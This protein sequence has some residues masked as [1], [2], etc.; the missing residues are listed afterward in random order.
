MFGK[1]YWNYDDIL[2]VWV[3]YNIIR[4]LNVTFYEFWWNIATKGRIGLKNNVKEKN[5]ER[6]PT[7]SLSRRRNVL[8][9]TKNK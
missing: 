3:W 5:S 6:C 7:Q 9:D 8:N 1:F 4:V 2:R